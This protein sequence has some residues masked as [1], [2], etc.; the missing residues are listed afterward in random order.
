MT[1][2]AGITLSGGQKQRIALARALYRAP[3]VFILDDVLSA[4]DPHVA[5]KLIEQCLCSPSA[6]GGCTRVLVTNSLP[7]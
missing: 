2:F 1:V 6:M 7:A 4:V 3:D 5:D